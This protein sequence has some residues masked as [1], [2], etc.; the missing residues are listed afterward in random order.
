MSK[1]NQNTG[2]ALILV[3]TIIVLLSIIASSFLKTMR[4]E[5]A[6]TQN[7]QSLIKATALA[8]AGINYAV[9][10]LLQHDKSKQWRSDYSLYEIEFAGS[11]IRIL[12]T[13]ESGKVNINYA[14]KNLLHRLLKDVQL[15]E[16][17]KNE[18][19]D[20]IIDWKD[21]DDIRE[22]YG[23]EKAEYTHLPYEPSNKPFKNIE[24]LQLVLGMT[25]EIYQALKPMLTIYSNNKKINPA[26]ASKSLL[27]NLTDVS[28]TVLDEYLLEKTSQ[29][30]NGE[31][32]SGFNFESDYLD[33]ASSPFYNLIAEVKPLDESQGIQLS[34]IIKKGSTNKNQGFSILKWEKINASLSLFDKSQDAFVINALLE[35]GNH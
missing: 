27:S 19:I 24:E 28:E 13:D 6:V 34:A 5:T 4:R 23:A 33:N 30:K 1:K 22:E 10:M 32:V 35:E 11:K 15:P 17:Q 25:I 3:L 21:K 20:A 2:F 7:Y 9:F 12:I 16:A 14:D 29:V 26:K 31:P 18:L 8:E